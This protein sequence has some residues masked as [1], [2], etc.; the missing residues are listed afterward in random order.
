[1]N[2]RKEYY[3]RVEKGVDGEKPEQDHFQPGPHISMLVVFKA[4]PVF[5]DCVVACV[6]VCTGSRLCVGN[7]P[8]PPT[9]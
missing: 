2:D 7:V 4:A 5:L 6:S 8:D 1:M 3:L 9:P